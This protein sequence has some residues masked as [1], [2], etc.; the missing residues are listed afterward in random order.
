MSEVSKDLRNIFFTET[1][2]FSTWSWIFFQVR[3]FSN[4]LP[5][6]LSETLQT[7][8]TLKTLKTFK[9]FNIADIKTLKTLENFHTLVTFET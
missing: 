4:F 7:L 1:P 5:R 8:E 2:D 3:I 9:Y 6:G